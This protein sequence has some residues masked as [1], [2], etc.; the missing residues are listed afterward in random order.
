MGRATPALAP[1]FERWFPAGERCLNVGCG[2][3]RTSGGRLVNRG[4]SYKGVDISAKAVEEARALGLNARRIGDASK[5][6]FVDASFNVVVC[7]EVPE[8]LLEPLNAV[9]E[10][11]RVLRPSGLL[12]VTVANVA[13]WRRRVDMVLLGRWNPVGDDPAVSEPWR[14]PHIRFF[15]PGSMRRMIAT[16]SLSPIEVGGHSGGLIRDVPWLSRRFRHREASRPY[17]WLERALPSLFGASLHAVARQ[18]VT[19]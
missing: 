3:G 2:D 14:D 19:L 18:D 16:V 9:R 6:P 11:A 15:H 4:R 7:V 5:P 17:R 8:H 1:L 12:T 13:Y 10:M